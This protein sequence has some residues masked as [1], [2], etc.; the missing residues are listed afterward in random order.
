MNRLP[1]IDIKHENQSV[2]IAVV[3]PVYNEVS[4]IGDVI[5]CIP[6]W[7]SSI[8]VVDDASLDDSIV[9]IQ[10]IKDS[11]INLVRHQI[12]LGVGKS[13]VSGYKKALEDGCDITVVMGGDGQMD[14]ADLPALVSPL[15]RQDADYVKGNRFLHADTNRVMP[16]HR[17]FGNKI[18]SHLTRWAAQNYHFF[19]SQ[20]GYTAISANLL[21][22]LPLDQ[23]YPRY[24]FPNDMLFRILEINGR[25]R[26]V[27]VRAIYGSEKSGIN[28]FTSV[29]RMLY[30]I[31]KNGVLFRYRHVLSTLAVKKAGSPSIKP[32][33]G[34]K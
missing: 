10:S 31:L 6:P 4:L 12:N 34:I 16:V 19:D 14:P 2:R 25:I 24:G 22:K 9:Q 13:I 18:L 17:H 5:R 21:Q 23:L 26:E 7:I 1:D 28:P 32:G 20:C 29:P 30:L 15:V 3:I 8:I 11:R 33:D 27:P